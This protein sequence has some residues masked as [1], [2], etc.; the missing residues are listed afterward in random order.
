MRLGADSRE[1][2]CNIEL[3]ACCG[4][5]ITAAV[6][7]I[8]LCTPKCAISDAWKA[9]RILEE[10][11]SYMHVHVLLGYEVLYASTGRLF[12]LASKRLFGD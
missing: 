11:P 12:G 1:L 8:G 2:V 6:F 3:S 4:E 5:G 10:N 7:Q 9:F